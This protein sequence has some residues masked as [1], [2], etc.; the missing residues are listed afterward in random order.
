[1]PTKLK[2]YSPY[3]P[4][5]QS[6]Y[7]SLPQLGLGDWLSWGTKGPRE[8]KQWDK[9]A[10]A[11]GTKLDDA[12]NAVMTGGKA[13]AFMSENAGAIG[14]GAGM[15]GSL[16]DIIDTR[17][18]KTSMGMSGASGALKGAGMG[19][20]FGP[21]GAIAG[22]AIGLATGLFTGKRKQEQEQEQ[23]LA[24]EEQEKLRHNI[25]FAGQQEQFMSD[26]EPSIQYAPTMEAKYGGY[27]MAN[28]GRLPGMNRGGPTTI[29]GQTHAG[30][31]GG[32]PTDAQ[33]NAS[34]NSRM[35]AVALTEGGEVTF[36]GYVYSDKIIYYG[37]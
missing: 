8:K 15:A 9:G 22:G 24:L 3:F 33:G 27:L 36:G 13:G 34:A 14:M 21:L 6:D 18:G 7:S 10:G 32:I 31:Q 30:P 19:M 4:L 20:M 16:L 25:E 28:G 1:M 17:D 37:K 23:L 29:T 2:E 5:D 11:W 35:P 12:G 26:L